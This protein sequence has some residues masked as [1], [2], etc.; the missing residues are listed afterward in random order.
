[1]EETGENAAQTETLEIIFHALN[2]FAIHQIVVCRYISKN[3][4]RSEFRH[5]VGLSYSHFSRV[6]VPDGVRQIYMT[7]VSGPSVAAHLLFPCGQLIFHILLLPDFNCPTPPS[8]P[9][10]HPLSFFPSLPSLSSSSSA[11]YP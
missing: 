8:S 11:H 3:W 9:F 1:M 6:C 10:H 7:S 4:K 2:A 5:R